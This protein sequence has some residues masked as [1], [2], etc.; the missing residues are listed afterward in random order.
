M[1]AWILEGPRLMRKDMITLEDAISLAVHAHRGQLDK[2]GQP[3][4]LHP[5]RV[6]LALRDEIEM[7]VGVLHDVIEDTGLTLADLQ[8][9]GYS[10]IV[11]E[12]LNILT[13]RPEDDYDDYIARIK[14]HPMA[15]QVKLADLK[16]NMDLSRLNGL[17]PRDQARMEKISEGP[18]GIIGRKRHGSDR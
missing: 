12:T 10:S 16:D 4:I 14:P 6:M 11:M 8:R 13:K 5:L 18:A 15:R 9:M 17:T 3:Y 7:M 1:S 2:A